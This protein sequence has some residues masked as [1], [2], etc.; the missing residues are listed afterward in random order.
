MELPITW[1]GCFLVWLGRIMMLSVVSAGLPKSCADLVD[2][3]ANIEVMFNNGNEA[4]CD[5]NNVILYVGCFLGFP[6]ELPRR[7]KLYLLCNNERPDEHICS[8]SKS[9]A[10]ISIKNQTMGCINKALCVRCITLDL[11]NVKRKY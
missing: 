1:L 4:V 5:N 2:R 6:I 8:D 9:D 10:K 3:S 7:K 11:N